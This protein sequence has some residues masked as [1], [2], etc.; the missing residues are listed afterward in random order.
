MSQKPKAAK[1]TTDESEPLYGREVFERLRRTLNFE[2]R[3]GSDGCAT[4]VATTDE[5][6]AANYEIRDDGVYLKPDQEMDSLDWLPACALDGADAP[7]SLTAPALPLPF[8]PQ[9]FGAFV[10]GGWGY[11]LGQRFGMPN[12]ELSD[13]EAVLH[14]S[15]QRDA[16]PREAVVKVRKVLLQARERVAKIDSTWENAKRVFN[17]I[18][19]RIAEHEAAPDELRARLAAAGRAM[20]D[21]EPAWRRAMVH[22]LLV[23]DP[24]PSTNGACEPQADE[25]EDTSPHGSRERQEQLVL[26]CLRDLGFDP[27]SLPTSGRRRGSPAKGKVRTLLVTCRPMLITEDQFLHTWKSLKRKGLIAER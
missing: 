12:G 25:A 21:A 1:M 3:L 8:K 19:G 9:H 2:V 13:E 26:R 27:T 20:N 5:Y 17:E 24:A 18:E 10:L 11:F 6:I 4:A 14:L 7:D 16:K 15:G 22:A 23:G